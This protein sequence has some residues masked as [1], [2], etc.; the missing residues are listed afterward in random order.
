VNRR[1]FNKLAGFAAAGA[2]IGDRMTARA[3]AAVSDV[4]SAASPF[5]ASFSVAEPF[6]SMEVRYVHTIAPARHP[7]LVYW[8]WHPNTLVDAEY[9]RDVERMTAKSQFTMAIATSRENIDPPGEGVD[10]YDFQRMHEPFAQTVRAAHQNNLRIGLQV[11]ESWA[12]TRAN[13]PLAKAHPRL[14][15][16]QSLALITEGEVVLD[17]QGHGEYSAT[18]TEGRNREAFHSELLRVF[19][20]RKTGDGVYAEDSLA[21]I[22]DSVRTVKS[23]G[24]S[25]TIA[26]DAPAIC[27]GHTAYVMAAHYYDYP[28]LFNE[29]AADTF[30]E[31]LMH[32]ADIPFDGT[33][34]DEFGYMMLKP[35]REHPFRDRFYGHAFAQEY[36]RRTGTALGRALFDMRFAPEGRPEV[37]ARAINYYFD[38][39][40]DGPLRVEQ[41]F[42]KMSKQIFGPKTFAGIHNTY[43]NTFRTDDLWRV[44]FNWWSVPREYGQ[45]DENWPMPKR[46]GLIMAHNEPV[47]FDQYYGGNLDG[48]LQ[49]AFREARFGGRTHYLAWNDT[50][51]GRIDMAEAVEEGKYAAID[52]AEQK[53]RLLNQFDPPAPRL[54]VL[55]IFGMPALI[56]WFPDETARSA[57][58]INGKLGLDEKA[59]SIWDAGY[60]CALLPSDFIDSGDITVDSDGRPA[61]N[62]HQFDC[63]VFLYPQYAKEATLEFLERYTERG[64]KLML[65]GDASHDFSGRD[66]TARFESLAARA[67]VRGIEINAL[68]QL[69]AQRNQLDGGALMEDGSVIFTD[70]ASWQTNQAKPFAVK[71]A[72]HEFSGSY[73][74]VCALKVDGAGSVEKHA[75]GGFKDLSCDGRQMLSLNLRADAV[76]TRMPDG[77]YKATVVAG[78]GK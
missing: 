60:P 62:G 27:A 78:S 48:F 13:D 57:W 42:Y 8:F 37:R 7:Q 53:I 15:I 63:M 68:P 69:G 3:D 70:I 59:Q 21:D 19:A 2:S 25:I 65:E 51:T 17:A 52:A 20:F 33:A 34:L 6:G 49:K 36:Q 31:F 14:S 77:S 72:G 16:D 41:A 11:W 26:I 35:Q 30:R 1:Q 67:T 43:H 58:D 47:T 73:I 66:I 32:Y 50:R 24:P 71:L 61:I 23:E 38:V 46:M 28:D 12:L 4:P 22:T 18:S 76:I 74:G 5:R 10:F 45:S 9:L 54:S 39:M 29:V 55:V 64:G 40:R 75:C 56:N 44:G